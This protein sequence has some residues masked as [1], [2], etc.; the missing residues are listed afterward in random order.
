MKILNFLTR[1]PHKSIPIAIIMLA[2][3]LLGVQLLMQSRAST[4]QPEGKIV[5]TVRN[6][7]AN[8]PVADAKN[9][10]NATQAKSG[11]IVQFTVKVS[12][13][14]KPSSGGYS[15]LLNV[16]VSDELPA[17]LVLAN[18]PSAHAV[19]LDF[20]TIA[21]GDS[22]TKQFNVRIMPTSAAKNTMVR[23][24]ACYTASNNY[25]SADLQSGCD[26]ALVHL[27]A[28][29]T[30][31]TPPP[32]T[33]PTPNPTPASNPTPNPTVTPAPAPTP[34]AT[35]TTPSRPSP[36]PSSTTTTAPSSNSPTV[37][38]SP[39]A[40]QAT[41]SASQSEDPD[42]AD[43]SESEPAALSNGR[44]GMPGSWVWLTALL[45]LMIL[46]ALAYQLWRRRHHKS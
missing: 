45:L 28:V 20:G 25:S 8:S 17:G 18:N 36:T 38:P 46:G 7:T 10:A 30:T 3:G 16:T 1:D 15:D 41:S 14:A 6:V 43:P 29:A 44:P 37:S 39:S 35:P 22:A 11:D 34:S 26:F 4:S 21:A 12:N 19:N 32:A 5:L 31:P 9:P 42:A 23:N 27:R 24:Q 2:S 13:N 40:P 33:T